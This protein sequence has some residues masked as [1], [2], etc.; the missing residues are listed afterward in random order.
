[1]CDTHRW[2]THQ[3][4][5]SISLSQLSS[6]L[7]WLYPTEISAQVGHYFYFPQD[8]QDNWEY[9]NR[10]TCFLCQKTSEI[11]LLALPSP[12]LLLA[13]DD[14]EHFCINA[15]FIGMFY[16]NC[17]PSKRIFKPNTAVD[18][19]RKPYFFQRE[20]FLGMFSFTV[21]HGYSFHLLGWL[22]QFYG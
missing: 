17:V 22:Q 13:L 12:M 9:R 4:G 8:V 6:W 18:L 2:Y 20:P 15:Y 1:M 5:A 21:K 14:S 16:I 11:L 10:V 3:N 7:S 19:R